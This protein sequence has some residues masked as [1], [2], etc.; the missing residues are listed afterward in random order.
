M[1]LGR[2]PLRLVKASAAWR[3]VALS[4]RAVELADARAAVDLDAH[5]NLAFSASTPAASIAAGSLPSDRY[6][7]GRL[8][9]AAPETIAAF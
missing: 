2:E 3:E 7:S 1:D 5:P 9:A 6:H 8:M 4:G